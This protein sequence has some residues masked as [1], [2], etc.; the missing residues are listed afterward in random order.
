MEEFSLRKET[1][2]PAGGWWTLVP[3]TARHIFIHSRTRAKILSL[4]FLREDIVDIIIFFFR[5]Y[6]RSYWKEDNY[7]G[8]ANY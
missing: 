3:M 6:C 2:S 5:K 8:P 7:C 1:K 4:L